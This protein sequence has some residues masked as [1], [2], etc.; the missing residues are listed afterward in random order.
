MELKPRASGKKTKRVT[1]AELAKSIE[2]LKQGTHMCSIYRTREEQLSLIVPFVAQGL[3]NHEKCFYIVDE[4]TREEIGAALKKSGID[5]ESHINRGDF[6]FLD[7]EDAYLRDGFFDPDR[8]ISLL[9][10]TERSALEE[11]YSGLR[12][13]GEMTW[14]FTRLPGVERLMEYE[15]KLN[16]FLPQSKSVA[17]CQYNESRFDH[18]ILIE[19]LK[20]HPNVFIYNAVVESPYYLPPDVFLSVARGEVS[21]LTYERMVQDVLQRAQAEG[22]RRR[23]EEELRQREKQVRSLL[24]Q[25]EESRRA[26]LSILEDQRRAEEALK[27]Y[28]ERLE[29]TVQERTSDLTTANEQLRREVT[30]RK[31]ADEALKESEYRYAT[32]Q[33]AANI[34]SWDWDIQTGGLV[35]SEQIEPMFGFE[36]GRFGGTYEAFLDCV[37]AEDRQFVIDSVDAAV[38]EH[39]DYAIEHRIVWPDG[40]VRWVSETGEVH[41]DEGGVPVRMVGIVRDVTELVKLRR[42]LEHQVTLLQRALVPRAPEVHE[43][44]SVAAAYLPAFAGQEIG[45]DFYDVFPT[46]AGQIGIL[47]GDVSGKG[48]EAAALAAASRSTIRSFAYEMLR[49]DGCLS[50]TNT[51]L[52]PQRQ[53]TGDF[54]TAFLIILDPDVGL[55]DYCCA[56]HPPAVIWRADG[57]VEP[58]EVGNPPLGISDKQGFVSAQNCLSLGDKVVLYTDGILEA[59][60]DGKILDVEG[61]CGAVAAHGHKSPDDLTAGIIRAAQEWSGGDLRDDVAILVIERIA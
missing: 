5:I 23:A 52:F 16:F 61:V 17:I 20:T 26:L 51:V 58:L 34:G 43:G 56:G 46:E 54:V 48:I 24:E 30:E 35:W 10:E 32:A 60:R 9:K 44:Y 42:S 41:W 31:Q 8:M 15:A 13:T 11:G 14:V 45:G 19:V 6:V 50:H 1:S 47:I 37:H 55:I 2:G 57:S 21:R 59:R 4:S 40:T 49:A 53:E 38:Y 28:S 18:E 3:T 39:A 22:L 12:V 27:E 25:S 36:R 7:K 29:D 33:R